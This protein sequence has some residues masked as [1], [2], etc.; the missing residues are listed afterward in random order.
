[1]RALACAAIFG[2]G[3]LA[4]GVA[5]ADPWTDPAGRFVVNIPHGWRINVPSTNGFSYMKAGTAERECVFEATP[6][7]NTAQATPQRV[8]Q[9]T[10]D[11]TQFTEEAWVRLA[12]QVNTVFP[13]NSAQFVSRSQDNSGFWPL[14]RADLRSP[15]GVGNPPLPVSVVHAA[16]QS[17]PGVELIGFCYTISDP[18]YPTPDNPALFDPIL[19]SLGTA[20]DAAL[21]AAAE[22]AATAPPPAPAPAPPP[23]QHH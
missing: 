9:S 18:D 10:Q 5:A 2:L 20:N 1:M 4:T 12:N 21:Q 13:N 6:N 7:P 19:R 17:R 22:A 11:D 8:R 3:L 23:P 16:L 14:Q 15:N